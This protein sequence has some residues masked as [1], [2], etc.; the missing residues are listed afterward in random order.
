MLAGIQ[1][2]NASQSDHLRSM[3]T[4]N[5]DFV[6]SI[7]SAQSSLS[8]LESLGTAEEVEETRRE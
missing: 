7:I 4:T 1:I 8:K 5:C 3:Y 6:I 2:G